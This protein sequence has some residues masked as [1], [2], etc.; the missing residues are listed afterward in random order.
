MAKKT[1]YKRNI[2]TIEQATKDFLAQSKPKLKESTFARYSFI[3]ERHIIPYFK[4]IELYS[5]N[6]EAVKNFIQDKLYNGG[7]TGKPISAK[8]VN[9]MTCLLLQIIKNYCKLTLD[10]EKPNYRQNEINIF[11]EAEY[12]KLKAYL[13]IGVDS[14][15]LGIVVA[16]LTGIRIGE[17]CALKWDKIDLESGV[18]FID[19]TMQRIKVTAGIGKAKTKIIIDTPK[20]STSIRKIPIPSILLSK[21]E[22]FRASQNAYLLTNTTDYIEPR[23][24]QRHFKSYLQACTIKDNN[25]H[26]LRHTFATLAI[27]IGMDIKTLSLLLGHTDVSFTMKRYVHPSMEHKRSQIEKLAIRF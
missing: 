27:S 19:K 10:V 6:D 16:M 11:T 22:S 2:K 26:T 13:S 20:S 12:N 8:T 21:L 1:H 4:D 25:F 5:L 23:I 14:K 24:Y 18:I 9:D 17:L 15:K 3:C 7:L